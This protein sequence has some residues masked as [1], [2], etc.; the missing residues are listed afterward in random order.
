MNLFDV[1]ALIGGLA[2]FL[3]GMQLMGNALEKDI[4]FMHVKFYEHYIFAR[5]N[6][7]SFISVKTR[8]EFIV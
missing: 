5:Y 7:Q 1:L 8:Q 3:F 4:I 6:F 2:L